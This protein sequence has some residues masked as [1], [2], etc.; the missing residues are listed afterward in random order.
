MLL[1]LYG[2]FTLTPETRTSL[3]GAPQACHY[4]Y[5]GISYSRVEFNLNTPC[6]FR[7]S[8]IGCMR[9]MLTPRVCS[10][11]RIFS[12]ICCTHFCMS[13]ALESGVYYNHQNVIIFYTLL[14]KIS[15]FGFA[16]VSWLIVYLILY[17]LP[18]ILPASSFIRV[19]VIIT[20]IYWF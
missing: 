12:K 13:T 9:I 16:N 4:Y 6:F 2:L 10:F 18:L 14:V 5:L 20:T 1:L 3:S 15:A 7:V 8:K 17:T 19:L 11:L